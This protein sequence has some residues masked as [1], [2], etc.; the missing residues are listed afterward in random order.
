MVYIYYL[1][2]IKDWVPIIVAPIE[3]ILMV[4]WGEDGRILSHLLRSMM[5]WRL[6][7][8]VVLMVMMIVAVVAVAV[9]VEK[10]I[11]AIMIVLEVFLVIWRPKQA[12]LSW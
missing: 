12:M 3:I 9:L 6:R 11:T 10:V 4:R 1:K 7:L 2:I 5:Y 8:L